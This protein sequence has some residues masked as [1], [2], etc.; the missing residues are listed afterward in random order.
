MEYGQSLAPSADQES[1]IY[2][3]GPSVTAFTAI[4]ILC[5]HG[6]RRYK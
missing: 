3:R 5:G 4:E 2:K 1:L 6:G